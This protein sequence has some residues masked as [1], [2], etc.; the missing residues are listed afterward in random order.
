MS[1]FRQRVIDQL[2]LEGV[3][4]EESL[5]KQL[6]SIMR[7]E[8]IK[9]KYDINKSG[10]RVLL[11]EEITITPQ[12]AARGMMIADALTGGTLG[13]SPKQVM[14]SKP[15]EDLHR[16]FLPKRDLRVVANAEAI[17]VEVV[18]EV[19]I[20][21]HDVAQI[22]EEIADPATEKQVF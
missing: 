13:L 19:P 12:A 6:A 9:R 18:Q 7:G 11:S 20:P 3:L 1:D 8:S 10:E 21:L 16:R 2:K 17:H 22:L 5:A 4:D 15:E 14:I